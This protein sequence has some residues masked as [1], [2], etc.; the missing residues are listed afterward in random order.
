[1]S[2]HILLGAQGPVCAGCLIEPI[3]GSC[4]WIRAPVL[5]PIKAVLT[6]AYDD[7]E[8]LQSKQEL[9]QGICQFHIDWEDDS[10]VREGAV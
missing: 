7:G 8:R 2:A 6:C 3:H 4:L 1:M 10:D 9:L 5:L